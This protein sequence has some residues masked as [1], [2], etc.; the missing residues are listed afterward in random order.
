[1]TKK[2]TK[3]MLKQDKTKSLVFLVHLLVLLAFASQL[4]FCLMFETF[5]L[6]INLIVGLDI[7][8]FEFIGRKVI[9]DFLK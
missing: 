2:K 7:N 6:I 1:M 8:K 9:I 5:C 4:Y 3:I